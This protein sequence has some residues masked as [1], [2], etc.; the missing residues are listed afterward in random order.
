MKYFF[1]AILLICSNSIFA[2]TIFLYS[3][4][5]SAPFQKQGLLILNTNNR[6]TYTDNVRGSD[7]GDTD[8]NRYMFIK[9][10]NDGLLTIIFSSDAAIRIDGNLLEVTSNTKITNI[11][12]LYRTAEFN[13]EVKN[14]RILRASVKA[15]TEYVFI[16]VGFGDGIYNLRVSLSE[17]EYT[18]RTFS[19]SLFMGS[20]VRP[21][22]KTNAYFAGHERRTGSG[23]NIR[24]A[25][26]FVDV[27]I[28]KD[29][30][31]TVEIINLNNL[32]LPNL[33]TGHAVTVYFFWR[34]WQYAV[35][36]RIETDGKYFFIGGTLQTTD[37]L[38]LRNRAGL[39]GN[40]LEILPAY[41]QVKI[42]EET[43]IDTIDGITSAWVKVE[44]L[45]TGVTGWC[46]GGY[47]Q[48]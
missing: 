42:I 14:S 19:N 43:N 2:Q 3:N 8:F 29:Q 18:L 46:F 34:T 30:T 48:P 39:D 22:F 35:L 17:Y 25:G 10:E 6:N 38:R 21:R 11:E 5:G 23:M 16:F 4:D 15:D 13:S 24:E 45:H 1:M 32:E 41:T 44:V 9:S 31:R 20:D 26:V 12:T 28:F 33:K 37:N 36:E 27:L 40:I 47:L 7:Y